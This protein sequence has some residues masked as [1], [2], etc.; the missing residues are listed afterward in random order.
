MWRAAYKLMR[1]TWFDRVVFGA[2]VV[3]I[4]LVAYSTSQNQ[5]LKGRLRRLEEHRAALD[6]YEEARS[7][8]EAEKTKE[9]AARLQAERWRAD[10]IDRLDDLAGCCDGTD[11]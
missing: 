8:W 11:R 10:V 3:A 7:T 1:E 6:Q 4:V 5:V 9:Q 2:L